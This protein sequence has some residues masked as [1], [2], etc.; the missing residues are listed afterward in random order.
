MALKRRRAENAVDIEGER[1]A[2]AL[3]PVLVSLQAVFAIPS[4]SLG[5]FE[6]ERGNPFDW[7]LN[8]RWG[9]TE[10]YL[11]ITNCSFFSRQVAAPGAIIILGSL[12]LG[13]D[14]NLQAP[15]VTFALFTA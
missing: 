14:G 1:V 12:N 15:G 11:V 3:P 6:I 10:S 4:G 8:K 2:E 7:V 13:M 9:W 5:Y